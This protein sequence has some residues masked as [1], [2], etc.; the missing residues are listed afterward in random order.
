MEL[1]KLRG[2]LLQ[3]V[4]LAVL[5]TVACDL[6]VSNGGDGAGGNGGA[7]GGVGASTECSASSDTC[8]TYR[9]CVTVEDAQS[10]LT[11]GAAY[12]GNE[13]GFGGAEGCPLP[14]YLNPGDFCDYRGLVVEDGL[15]CYEISSVGCC[16]YEGGAG[17]PFIVAGEVRRAEV[18][19]REG[20]ARTDG[21]CVTLDA[22]TKAAIVDGWIEDARLE[23]ASIAAF[24]RFTMQLLAFGAPSDMVEAS[25]RA[26]ADELSHARA[27]FGLA[28]RYDG[29]ALGPGVL[30]V[31]DALDQSSLAEVAVA[32]VIEGC[33]GE[34][35]AAVIASRQLNVAKDP[36]AIVALRRI[37]EDEARHAEL[38]WRFVA[39]AIRRDAEARIAVASAFDTAL[40]HLAVDDPEEA[41]IAD[42]EVL[43]QHGRLTASERL[44]ARVEALQE[45]VLPCARALLEGRAL[46]PLT[47]EAHFA[48]TA[49]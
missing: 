48:A 2:R 47:A 32:A 31:E 19:E 26:G 21:G 8:C 12:L 35:I 38:A 20:W 33:I 15:C 44:T 9:S 42:T 4:G 29:R 49:A 7:A 30:A 17:R 27:C 23:H 41:N 3:I 37:S 39:W 43:H 40:C 18:V 11:G 14:K 34:T 1:L 24:A 22:A 28:S 6:G 5:G 16:N 36:L 13:G 10:G 25:I 46:T 45:V